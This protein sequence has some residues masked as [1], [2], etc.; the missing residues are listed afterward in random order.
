MRVS[1]RLSPT[2]PLLVPVTICACNSSVLLRMSS[3]A[4]RLIAT[5]G[6]VRSTSTLLSALAG[7]PALSLT[8]AVTLIVPSTSVDSAAAGTLTLQVPSVPT[9]AV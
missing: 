3:P 9:V 2:V 5:V 4:I 8:L 7:L 1:T 6:A